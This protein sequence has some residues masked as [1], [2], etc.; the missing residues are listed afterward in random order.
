VRPYNKDNLV[1]AAEVNDR[2]TQNYRQHTVYSTYCMG[3]IIWPNIEHSASYSEPV[4]GK[5]YFKV[6]IEYSGPGVLNS[7]G[8]SCSSTSHEDIQGGVKV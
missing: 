2:Y 8:Q 5:N 3:R 6:I 1:S 4:K 7:K